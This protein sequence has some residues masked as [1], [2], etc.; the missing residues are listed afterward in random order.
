MR[1]CIVYVFNFGAN[2]GRGLSGMD[3]APSIRTA[4]MVPVL[5][6]SGDDRLYRD[7]PVSPFP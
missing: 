4:G 2:T 1:F 5:E 7:H 3:S 6:E